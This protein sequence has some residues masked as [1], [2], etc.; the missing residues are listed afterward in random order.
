MW[1][2]KASQMGEA[3]CGYDKIPVTIIKPAGPKESARAYIE[4]E[5]DGVKVRRA[6]CKENLQRDN[7]EVDLT[8]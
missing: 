7:S 2:K 3:Y 4:F 1:F 5:K 8:Q 6:V